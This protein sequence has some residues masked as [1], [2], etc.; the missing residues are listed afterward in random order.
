MNKPAVLLDYFC[1]KEGSTYL[2]LL[3]FPTLHAVRAIWVKKSVSSTFWRKFISRC[4]HHNVYTLFYKNVSRASRS[5]LSWKCQQILVLKLSEDFLKFTGLFC[6]FDDEDVNIIYRTE[7]TNT[8]ICVLLHLTF[9][10]SFILR[11]GLPYRCELFISTGK[12]F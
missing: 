12:S 3:L 4:S 9:S 7:N 5:R 6:Y 1:K 11:V 10:I 2:L 8:V